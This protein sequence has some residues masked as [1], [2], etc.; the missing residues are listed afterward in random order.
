MKR[1]LGRGGYIF[2]FVAWIMLMCFPTF[3]FVLATRGEIQIGDPN[4]RN[5]R[6]FML[7]EEENQ[8]VGLQWTRRQATEENCWLTTV[9]Y[10]L[11]QGENTNNGY[12]TRFCQCFD[13]QGGQL[14]LPSSCP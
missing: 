13:A 7:Q 5:L 10:L 12:D 14:I 1:W 4:R 9:H 2:V 6:L 11:W 3:A 8:G